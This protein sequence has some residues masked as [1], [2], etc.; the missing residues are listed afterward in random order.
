MTAQ[1]TGQ[2][3]L[4]GSGWQLA[5]GCYHS[6]YRAAAIRAT[7]IALLLFGIL[8]LIVLV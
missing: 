3:S 1:S 4:P 6:A 5:P 2:E 7:F 8:A